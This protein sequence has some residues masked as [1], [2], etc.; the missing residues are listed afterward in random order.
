MDTILLVDDEQA[1][2]DG[3]SNLLKLN[4][5][6]NLRTA[7]TT[8]EARKR[9]AEEPI[10]LVIL[11][12][13]LGE[14][15]GL[16]LLD[17]I[18]STSPDTVVLIVTGATDIK[19]A[20][21][22]M[23][24]GAYDFLVKSSD[25]ARLPSAV[26]NAIHHRSVVKENSRLREAFVGS[27][28]RNPA[29][30][31]GF[32]TQCEQM[33]RIFLYLEAVAPLPDP[34]LITGETGV[35]KEVIARAV[36]NASG[37][38]GP[39]VAL[40]LGGL[41]DHVVADTLF[42]HER[43]AFTGA[44][45]ARKGLVRVATGGTLFLDEF[46]ELSAESQTKLLRLLDSGEFMSLGS[47]RT[48]RAQTR[49]VLATNRDLEAEIETGRFRRDLYFRVAAHRVHIP[50]LRERPEDIPAI[51][52]H[53]VKSHSER[54]G[55]PGVEPDETTLQKIAERPLTG[56]VREL[57][58]LALNALIAG[59]WNFVAEDSSQFGA[60]RFVNPVLGSQGTRNS[61]SPSGGERTAPDVIFGRELPTPSELV[62]AL[63]READRRYPGNRSAAAAA[64]RLSAQAFSNRWRRLLN[65]DEDSSGA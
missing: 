63:L 45:K 29:V 56:N 44:D 33:H 50:P 43:G 37:V 24:A 59:N 8:G 41:D 57:E 1:V 6:S 16:E 55:R 62:D 25:T 21:R 34:L 12:L 48:E 11:D 31:A 52:R 39:F 23:Q 65:A 42:G 58:Q 47:D 14:S 40:N 19:L 17:W 2:L 26:R 64:V 32:V 7:R 15:S 61:S 54:L 60:L 5:Y 18:G 49:I 13:T 46:A 22:C 51:V 35:G 9:F 28:P 36:H 10:A 30:F 4:G 20:V 3:Q 53:L 27:G 38:E